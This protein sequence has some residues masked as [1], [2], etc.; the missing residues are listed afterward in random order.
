MIGEILKYIFQGTEGA[1]LK[2]G[3]APMCA[4]RL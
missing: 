4:Y 1:D 3:G 2:P